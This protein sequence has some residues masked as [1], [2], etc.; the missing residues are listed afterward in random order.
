MSQAL[1][2]HH[3]LLSESITLNGGY[4]F[5]I[6]GDAFCS[7]FTTAKDGLDAELDAQRALASEK[8]G[9]TGA[10]RVRMAL[11]TG[12]AEVQIGE[13]TSGEYVSG[14]TLSRAARLLSAGLGGQILVSLATAELVRDHL[15]KGTTLRDLGAH[16]LKDLIRPEHIFQVIVPDLPAEFLPLKTLDT[17][18]NNLPIQLTSFVGREQEMARVK[19]ILGGARFLTLTGTGGTGK[20]RL[21]IQVAAELIDEFPDGVWFIELASL[22][23]PALIPQT[24][25]SV[26]G[27]HNESGQPLMTVLCDYLRA[28]TT[29]L[30]VDN[31]ELLIDG[32]SRFADS[33]LHAA[34][35]LKIL[36]ASREALGIGGETAYRVPSLSSPPEDFRRL[37]DFGSLSQYEAVRLFIDRVLSVQPVFNVTKT[38]A[39]AVAKICHR[40]DGIPL[41]IE[42]AAA[43]VK[44]LSVDQIVTR[45]DDAFHLLTGGSRTAL[46]R[47]QTL[48]ALIDWSH[49]LLETTERV[50]FR[51]LAVFA[52]GW[53]L[54]AAESICAGDGIE[55][56]AVLDLLQNLVDK[57]LVVVDEQTDQRLSRYHLLETVRQYAR[58]K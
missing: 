33:L 11:H 18:P 14:L 22:G 24:V 54:D 4:T 8:R 46:P 12:R 51:R 13:Y 34:P 45:L 30:V 5:Q 20:T 37:G 10:I 48:R 6:I 7:A 36:A 56:F 2:R 55:T 49:G 41:A 23:D 44:V 26:L 16:R 47:Q 19:E 25:V 52:G 28:K 21:A 43:R 39:P 57:S 50:L 29:L 38:N 15:P 27:L 31:C 42:L 53:R 40:L 3:M 32:C 17:H 58:E 1:N 35:T 9:A